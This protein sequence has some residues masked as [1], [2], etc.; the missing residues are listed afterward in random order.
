MYFLF[1]DFVG[2]ELIASGSE[3]VWICHV[4]DQERDGSFDY[5]A[6][7]ILNSNVEVSMSHKDR[8]VKIII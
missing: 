1:S 8:W 7:T 6:G 3:N 4:G 2:R 5:F